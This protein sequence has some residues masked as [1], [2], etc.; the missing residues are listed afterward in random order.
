MD[1]VVLGVLQHCIMKVIKDG[2]VTHSV[3]RL[4]VEISGK[5]YALA[6]LRS[7]GDPTLIFI[8]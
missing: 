6:T 2:S 5:I 1:N 7:W 3:P 8:R 4:E